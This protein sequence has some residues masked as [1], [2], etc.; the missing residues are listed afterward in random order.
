ML[1]LVVGLGFGEI[2]GGGG[3]EPLGQE[4]KQQLS[5]AFLPT[6]LPTFLSQLLDDAAL[7]LFG[8]WNR[9]VHECLYETIFEGLYQR[10]VGVQCSDVRV[11]LPA[12][13]G[14]RHQ[15]QDR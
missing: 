12:R 15:A 13:P 5:A 4:G 2:G 6:F 9:A 8:R 7:F 11:G 3:A 14:C 10:R 1:E